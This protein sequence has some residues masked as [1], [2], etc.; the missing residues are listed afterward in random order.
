MKKYD[1][2]VGMYSASKKTN[3]DVAIAQAAHDTLVVLFP[4]Q[5][6]LFDT[7]LNEDLLQ[8]RTTPRSRMP[9]LL[10]GL[11]LSERWGFATTTDRSMRSRA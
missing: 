6:A 9:F 3:R 4:S 10:A 1:S 5:K 8:F 11:L 7:K 2:H